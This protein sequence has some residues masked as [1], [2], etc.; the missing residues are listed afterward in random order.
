[1][2][3]AN[4]PKYPCVQQWPKKVQLEAVTF[5]TIIVDNT[6]SAHY[7]DYS[8]QT[9]IALKNHKTYDRFGFRNVVLKEVSKQL[10]GMVLKIWT[11][12]PD[13]NR[14]LSLANNE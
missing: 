5:C 9:D 3:V 8:G 6:P 13:G 10:K 11:I 12:S 4:E 1:M 14:P 7:K 2:Y